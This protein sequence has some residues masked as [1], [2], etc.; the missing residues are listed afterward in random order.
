MKPTQELLSFVA[1]KIGEQPGITDEEIREQLNNYIFGRLMPSLINADYREVVYRHPAVPGQAYQVTYYTVDEQRDR[2]SLSEGVREGMIEYALWPNR[3][4]KNYLSKGADVTREGRALFYYEASGETDPRNREILWLVDQN[5]DNRPAYIEEKKQQLIAG[6][7]AEQ[8]AQKEAEVFFTDDSMRK[9]R[10][11]LVLD[12]VAESVEIAQRVDELSSDQLT[13]AQLGQNYL[14]MMHALDVINDLTTYVGQATNGNDRMEFTEEQL[15]YLRQR[16]NAQPVLRNAVIPLA[17]MGNPYYSLLNPD[18]IMETDIDAL[19]LTESVMAQDFSERNRQEDPNFEVFTAGQGDLFQSYATDVRALRG[20]R[21]DRFDMREQR[22]MQEVYGF[23][24]EDTVQV[25]E[26]NQG[27]TLYR[28]TDTPVGNGKPVAYELGNRVVI[29]T[30]TGINSRRPIVSAEQPE[31]LFNLTLTQK[32]ND[33]YELLAATDV[34]YKLSSPEY[35]EMKRALDRVRS[36]RPLGQDGNVDKR[37]EL[38]NARKRFETLLTNTNAY[39]AKKPPHSE[40]KYENDRIQAA[41]QVRKYAE[42]KLRQLELVE[43]A[44]DTLERYRGMSDDEIRRVTAIENAELAHLKEQDA[45]REDP[46]SWF[47]NLSDRYGTQGLPIVFVDSFSSVIDDLRVSPRDN[48]G[49]FTNDGDGSLALD[50]K[51]L[52]GYSVAGE[53]ILRERAQ[54]AENGL[55]G[56]GPLEIALFGG[57]TERMKKWIRALGEQV[58]ETGVGM[59][60]DKLN[61]EDLTHFL[62]SFDPKVMAD[63][64]TD[65]FS[66]QCGA[67]YVNAVEEK[68]RDVN[69]AVREFVDS[70]ILAR[71]REYQR[72]ALEGTLNVPHD[73]AARIV[74]SHA[75]ADLAQ[76][77]GQIGVK[78][79]QLM[80]HQKNVDALLTCI[81]GDSYVENLTT[82]VDGGENTTEIDAF[83]RMAVI[84][85]DLVADHI[86]K[87]E[88]FVQ[89]VET[90]FT[91]QRAAQARSDEFMEAVASQYGKA[92]FTETPLSEFVNSSIIAP[93]Q[94]Y[95]AQMEAMETNTDFAAGYRMMSSCVLAQLVQLEKKSDVLHQMMKSQDGIDAMLG[96]VQASDSFKNMIAEFDRMGGQ[97]DINEIPKLIQ[98]KQPQRAALGILKDVKSKQM[99]D[100][101][102]TE[103]K[104][105]AEHSGPQKG[106]AQPQAG[107]HH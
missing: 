106:N 89:T 107:G 85:I 30:A 43:K 72:Q 33:V 66:K 102:V 74:S 24:P 60:V 20:I 4:E 17:A 22:R 45:R 70:S 41:M 62:A 104:P 48:D 88:Q 15:E 31:A 103:R 23:I 101:V 78:L 91:A 90:M 84:C 68:Y 9:R 67:A 18:D 80:Q 69:L 52:A 14:A 19:I 93:A 71:T 79:R 25:S 35:R 58:I 2:R 98:G 61:R 95:K 3:L 81:Q 87:Q 82:S 54:R 50:A 39:L 7:M 94:T 92:P 10:S 11:K 8:Q 44:R 105:V 77:E 64:V 55:A 27:Y 59:S 6:G 37:Q 65:A 34:M 76:R 57:K 28:T 40:K 99:L 12:R 16:E 38:E 49:V 51:L 42:M 83:R 96:L 97:P 46:V 21:R 36:V 86:A 47:G 5:L 29:L 100:G 53:M 13:S 56:K 26:S 73:D 63:R 75:L 1:G 32:S